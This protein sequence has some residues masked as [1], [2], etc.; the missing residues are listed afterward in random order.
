MDRMLPEPV[1]GRKSIWL[2]R[3]SGAKHRPDTMLICNGCTY[4]REN[5]MW[6]RVDHHTDVQTGVSI[7]H[8]RSLDDVAT[9]CGTHLENSQ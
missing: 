1:P 4:Q 5:S 3:R 8:Y 9:R 2:F 6:F 7:R